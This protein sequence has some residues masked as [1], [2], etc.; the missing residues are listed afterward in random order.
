MPEGGVAYFNFK[1]YASDNMTYKVNK[2]SNECGVNNDIKL[3]LDIQ[4]LNPVKSLKLLAPFG[5]GSTICA[6]S[7]QELTLQRY[8]TFDAGARFYLDYLDDS[9]FIVE[10]GVGEF[11]NDKLSWIVPSKYSTI[12]LQVRASA[13]HYGREVSCGGWGY[14]D[15][16]RIKEINAIVSNSNYYSGTLRLDNKLYTTAVFD[17]GQRVSGYG[18]YLGYSFDVVNSGSFAI[19]N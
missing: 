3:S 13:L 5:Q 14:S 18:G 9:G 8:G 2:V 12:N 7:T 19:K 1:V 11:I 16:F 4:V 6:G 15:L 10:A 17:N